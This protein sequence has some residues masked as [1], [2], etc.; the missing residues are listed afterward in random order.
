MGDIKVSKK[1]VENSKEIIT[2]Y[3]VVE[4]DKKL[5]LSLC[6]VE[7]LTGRTHQIRAHMSSTGNPLLG[8]E[9]YGDKNL[10]KKYNKKHQQLCSYKLMFDFTDSECGLQYLNQK[11]YSLKEIPF[12]KNNKIKI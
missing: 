9:K 3:R 8:D 2:K 1:K 12:A 4:Y 11:E 5:N 7:L 10:N 6:E